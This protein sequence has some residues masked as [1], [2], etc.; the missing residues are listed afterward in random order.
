MLKYIVISYGKELV[1]MKKLLC[2]LTVL[3]AVFTTVP[4][5]AA[6]AAPAAGGKEMLVS[7]L[8]FII[9]IVAFYFILIKP[10]KK[11]EKETK[12][13]LN[14]IGVGDEIV[15]IGGIVG[16][17]VKVKENHVVIETGSDCVKLTFERGAIGRVTKK[18]EKKSKK[19]EE[20]PE[21]NETETTT[22]E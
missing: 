19:V 21:V 16:K 10:Q 3:T 20:A 2:L 22:E 1:V 12:E 8:P 7:F 11:R 6:P 9:L 17:V 4:V 13:M 5:F 15:T 14:A 18:N